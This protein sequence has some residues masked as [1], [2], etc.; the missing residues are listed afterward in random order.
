MKQVNVLL[1]RAV[2]F[3]EIADF[4]PRGGVFTPELVKEAVQRYEFQ[5]FPTTYDEWRAD[6]GAQFLGGHEGKTVI[7]KVSIWDYGIFMETRHS[8][9]ESKRL[10]VELF[11]WARERFGFDFREDR[12]K[13]AYVSGISFYSDAAILTTPPINKLAQKTSTELAKI[14]GEEANYEPSGFVI[15]HD[16]LERKYARAALSLQRRAEAPFSEGKYFSEAPLPTSTHIKLLEEYEQDVL[17]T[18]GSAKR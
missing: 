1:A 7:D 12:I 13:W 3:C 2:A 4:A 6:A 8:T 10:L 15:S 18:Y 11:Q 17:E 9:E 14:W 16:P 5:K